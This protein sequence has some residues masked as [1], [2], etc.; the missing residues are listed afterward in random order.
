MPAL[1]GVNNMSSNGTSSESSSRVRSVQFQS[2]DYAKKCGYPDVLD[3]LISR[4]VHGCYGDSWSL[5]MCCCQAVRQ[6]QNKLPLDLL[7]HWLPAI[8]RGLFMVIRWLPDQCGHLSIELQETLEGLVSHCFVVCDNDAN[9]QVRF[10]QE[11]SFRKKLKRDLQPLLLPIPTDRSTRDDVQ[12]LVFDTLEVINSE[13]FGRHSSRRVRSVAGKCLEK[14]CKATQRNGADLLK[15]LLPSLDKK[16]LVPLRHVE[17][18]IGTALAITFCLRQK[19]ELVSSPSA[20]LVQVCALRY[21]CCFSLL[22][23]DC[24]A[25]DFLS[26]PFIFFSESMNFILFCIFQ[27]FKDAL[28]IVDHDDSVLGAAMSQYH[29]D[30][31]AAVVRLRT[32]CIELLCSA[33]AWTAFRDDPDQKAVKEPIIRCF[34]KALTSEVPVI[35][36]AA[37]EGLRHVTA[38]QPRLLPKELLQS[39]LKPLLMNLAI[40]TSLNL[41]LLKGLSL[42]LEL[43][44]MWFNPNLGDKLLGHLRQWLKPHEILASNHAWSHGEEVLVAAAIMELFHLLPHLPRPEQF[45]E[46]SHQDC[47]GLVV[48][49]IELENLLHQYPDSP[50]PSKLCSPY[51]KPLTKFLNRYASEATRY[52]LET[53]RM[54]NPHYFHRFLSI[55]KSNSAAPL[56]T[57]LFE[58]KDSILKLSSLLSG[59]L[60]HNDPEKID[61]ELNAVHLLSVMVKI[62][63]IWMKENKSILSAVLTRWKS[64]GRKKR[65]CG[66]DCFKRSAMMETPRLARFVVISSF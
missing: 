34:F 1:D 8:M 26:F 47:P 65:L 55:I 44:S 40:H 36:V 31:A 53:A 27:V 11:E 18:Q 28:T 7:A 33:V 24:N 39:S 45:L 35:V 61:A 60:S 59:E 4:I 43:L 15:P 20:D 3:K 52:F 16:R 21:S 25:A 19:P 30:V 62:N 64:P 5:R 12:N 42:L 50:A 46:S 38:S 66:L 13:I 9:F 10:L 17:V 37:K 57:C 58:N 22:S 32:V 2:M 51:V 14:I 63:P 41:P 29:G 49:T 54:Q 56:R 48:L 23:Q 6:L